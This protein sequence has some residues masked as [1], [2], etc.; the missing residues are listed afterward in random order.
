MIN[1][2]ENLDPIVEISGLLFVNKH[3]GLIKKDIISRLNELGIDGEIF[4]QENFN[5]YEKYVTVFDKNKKIT[6]IVDFFFEDCDFSFSMLI[7]SLI[8][9]NRDLLNSM[10]GITNEEINTK[11]L[12]YYLDIYEDKLDIQQINN[13]EDTVEFLKKCKITDKQKW[14]LM[15]IMKGS[16]EYYRQLIELIKENQCAYDKAIKSIDRELNIAIKQYIKDMKKSSDGQFAKLVNLFSNNMYVYPTL[17]F[18]ISQISFNNYGYYGL[19]SERTFESG[20]DKQNTKEAMLLKLKALGDQSKFEILL[21]LKNFPKYNLELAE[22]LNLSSSTMS[23][24]MN[25]LLSCGLVE[26]SKRDGKVYYNIQREGVKKLL[27]S[28]EKHLI[29]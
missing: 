13:L 18:P 11:L 27:Y 26:V 3:F 22:Q 2:T 29:L 16:K 24:H 1:L 17:I 8:I 19:L 28:L 25:V 5:L 21:S 14:K 6:E 20:S 12:Y 23:H 10:D 7:I 9:E 4:Y 15:T